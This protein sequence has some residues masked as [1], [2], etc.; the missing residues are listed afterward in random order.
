MIISI[1]DQYVLYLLLQILK[2]KILRIQGTKKSSLSQNFI[3][4]EKVVQEVIS[5]SVCQL[6]E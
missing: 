3:K 6:P 2:K 4:L 5:F 1:L